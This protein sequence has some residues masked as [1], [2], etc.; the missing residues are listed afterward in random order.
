MTNLQHIE[1]IFVPIHGYE[2]LY[3]I[4]NL[5]RVKSCK[6]E[7][8]KYRNGNKYYQPIKEKFKR[9]QVDR[10]GYIVIRLSKNGHK[11]PFSIHRLVATHFIPNPENKP[12]VNH[13]FGVKTDNTIL[14]LEWAT[15]SEQNKHSLRLKLRRHPSSIRP[16]MLGK[17]GKN[18]NQSKPIIQLSMDGSIVRE[19]DCAAD[20]SREKGFTRTHIS[21]CCKG[22][23]E[24]H[25]GFKWKFKDKDV[26]TKDLV[27]EG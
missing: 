5:G 9:T 11:S 2:G 8:E 23:A 26:T 6:R 25:K 19:W 7:C 15:L 14:D 3:E 10:D 17:F 16:G 22:L 27:G 12:T 24:S 13:L 21:R 4:S 1:E 20:A 18:H